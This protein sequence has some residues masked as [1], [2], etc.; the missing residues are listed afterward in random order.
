MDSK[1]DTTTGKTQGVTDRRNPYSLPMLKEFGSVRALTQSGTGNQ[2]EAADGG[3][4]MNPNRQR[5]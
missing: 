1:T 3:T 2:A 4:M 5:P